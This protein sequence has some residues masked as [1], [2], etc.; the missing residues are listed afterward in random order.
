M[1][2][3]LND[4][5]KTAMKARDQGRVST[6]RLVLATIKDRDIALRAEDRCEGVTD[7]EILMILAKMIRQRQ[8]SAHTYEEAGRLDL[9]EQERREVEIIE[10]FLP[11]Q[12]T[13]PEI[14]VACS[15]VLSEVGAAGLKDMG[16]C[17]G[18][19]KEKYAGTMDFTKASALVK[20][21]L[22]GPPPA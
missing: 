4:A 14:K 16:K 17:M 19:L 3:L 18:K 8:E 7:D 6:L 15:E 20:D 22:K 5:L 13:E 9:A 11:R 12:L 1:R 21:M 2:T 10:S